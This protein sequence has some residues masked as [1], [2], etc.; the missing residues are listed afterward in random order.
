MPRRLV[1]TASERES[2]FALPEN[3]DDLIRYYTFNAHD[4]SII[5]LHRGDINRLGFAIQLC[6]MRYPGIILGFAERPFGPL[7][8]MVARQ[9]NIGADHWEAYGRREQTRREHLAELQSIFGF[10]SFGVSNYRKAAQILDEIARGT[11]KGIIL[12]TALV[13]HLRS[14]K[15]LLPTINTIESICAGSVTRATRTMYQLLTES[16][17]MGH[18]Q[19]LDALLSMHADS[20]ISILMWLRQ[21]PAAYNARHML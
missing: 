3:Q 19:Q 16:L 2:L 14:S 10:I 17:T 8:N 15:V 1:L 6:Y 13:E 7:L 11:G 9:L 21:P 18:R 12:A 5:R 4:L 20:K